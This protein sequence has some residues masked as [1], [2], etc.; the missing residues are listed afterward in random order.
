MT[1][2]QIEQAVV[3]KIEQF[4]AGEPVPIQ[5]D[6]VQIDNALTLDLTT[7]DAQLAINFWIFQKTFDFPLNKQPVTLPLLGPA[8][9]TAGVNLLTVQKA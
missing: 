2:Q 6:K 9:L 4:E 7:D 1:L 8:T 5:I 3:A